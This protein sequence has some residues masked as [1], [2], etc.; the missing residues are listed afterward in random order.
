M[1]RVSTADGT[2]NR[3]EF[4]VTGNK[5]DAAVDTIGSTASQVAYLKGLVGAS[6]IKVATGTADIDVSAG[7]YTAFLN[8]VTVAPATGAPLANV[9][10]V[11][12]LALATTGFAALHTTE[13]I[14]FAVA[15]KVDGTNWRTDAEQVT[16]AITGTNAAGRSVTLDIGGVGVSEQVRIMVVL[17]AEAADTELPFALIYSASAAPT[18]T[19]VAAG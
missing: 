16:T 18:V 14:Q 13:T 17:S 2:E 9:Q 11:F 8:L 12:D 4:E 15:R 3:L 7:D 6:A 1:P 10:I 19:P 5:E